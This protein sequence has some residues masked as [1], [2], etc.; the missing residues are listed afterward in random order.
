MSHFAID[1]DLELYRCAVTNKD[2]VRLLNASTSQ[3]LPRQNKMTC[4]DINFVKINDIELLV[5]V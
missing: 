5:H 3:F 2:L 1:I 4:H